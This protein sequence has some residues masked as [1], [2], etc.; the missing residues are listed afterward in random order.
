MASHSKILEEPGHITG[1]RKKF[2]SHFTE[3][4]FDLVNEKLK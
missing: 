3:W 4:G 2:L 1:R